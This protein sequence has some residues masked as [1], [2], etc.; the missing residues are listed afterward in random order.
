LPA[1]QLCYFNSAN[2]STNCNSTSR[3]HVCRCMYRLC[4]RQ[5]QQPETRHTSTA[6]WI[7][8]YTHM[9]YSLAS[10]RHFHHR[11]HFATI[12]L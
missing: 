12:I 11:G 3:T 5:L 6:G 9:K 7:G 2:N 4:L 8:V 1:P 10:Q